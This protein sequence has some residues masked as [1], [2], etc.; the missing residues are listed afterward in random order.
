VLDTFHSVSSNQAVRSAFDSRG[1]DVVTGLPSRREAASAIETSRATGDPYFAI[2]FV[3]DRLGNILSRFGPK[4]AQTYTLMV[5]QRIAQVLREDDRLFRWGE[6][7][8]LA[9]V[10]RSMRAEAVRT[11]FA[12]FASPH[13]EITLSVGDRSV[14]LPASLSSLCLPVWQAADTATLIDQIDAFVTKHGG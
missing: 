14:L 13:A 3:A 11:E 4:V 8:L 5:S 2:V 1:E 7:S 12:R 9:I 6:S 10:S